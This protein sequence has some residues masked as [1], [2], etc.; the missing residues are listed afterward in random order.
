[1]DGF[2]VKKMID[3]VKSRHHRYRQRLPATSSPKT[4][5][6]DGD[7]AI[8]CN[9]GHFDIEIDMACER[10]YGHTKNTIKLQVDLY[11]IDGK[12]DSSWPKAAS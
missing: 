11:T 6:P 8:V 12:D 9:I 1:M 5:P 3:A 10:K 2:E 7:K 4:F